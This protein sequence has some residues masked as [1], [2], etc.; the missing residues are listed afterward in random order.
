MK[1]C[2]KR[3]KHAV[4]R[5]FDSEAAPRFRVLHLRTTGDR[6][7]RPTANAKGGK[8]YSVG[9]DVLAVFVRGTRECGPKL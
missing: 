4:A 1:D 8:K 7:V 6:I 3:N 2:H 9:E 5:R